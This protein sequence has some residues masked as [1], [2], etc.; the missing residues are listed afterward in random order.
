MNKNISCTYIG[1]STT[2]IE[3]GGTR[4][5]T[6]PHFGKST[7]F[8]P[9]IAPLPFSP[10]DLPDL[11][12]V[13]LS[14]THFDHLHVASYKYISCS[15]PIIVPEGSE[16]AI[17]QFMPNPVIEL[18]H[19]AEHELSDGTKITAVPVL[20]H[21]SR[22]SHLRFTRSNAYL[23]QGADS[24]SSVFFCG[25]SKFGPHFGEIGNLSKIDLAILPIGS[26]EPKWLFRKSHMTPAEAV[27]AFENLKAEH[28]IPTHYGTFKLSLESQKAP[29]EWL[30]KIIADRPDLSERIHILSPGEKFSL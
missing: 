8:F 1:H 21:S 26:Y 10:A 14:H 5:I 15:V 13:L 20:H 22:I 3:I 18:S 16:R 24:A 11:S 9:R 23:I 17:G 7:L 25:D 28:M 2:L 4:I 6:D 19:Y 27:E 29:A 30:K 12:A